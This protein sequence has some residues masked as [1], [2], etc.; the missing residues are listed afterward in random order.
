[1]SGLL[2]PY[3]SDD[4]P[5]SLLKRSGPKLKVDWSDLLWAALTVGR[6]S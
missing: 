6:A 4:F 5:P 1:M 2:I 3:Q